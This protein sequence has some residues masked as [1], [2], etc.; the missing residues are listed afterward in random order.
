MSQTLEQVEPSTSAAKIR[1]ASIEPGFDDFN[2]KPIPPLAVVSL[3]LGICGLSGL[4]SPLGLLFAAF[5]LALGWVAVRQI[6][7]ADGGFSGGWMARSGVAVSAVLLFGGIGLHIYW[8]QT[9]LP[10]GCQRLSFSADISKKGFVIENNQPRFHPDVENLDGKQVF[11]KGYMYPEQKTDGLS[12]FILCRDN[13]QCCFGGQPKLTDMI[14]VRMSKGQTARY[15]DGMVSVSGTFRL[16]DLRRAGN[17]E[18]AF[19]LDATHFG[20]AKTWY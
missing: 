4:L 2:Y 19:E 3:L 7:R 10:E 11:L 16:R 12:T 8:Y 5:G 20:P 6:Q 13:G 17:L 15:G 9:E 18:P 1:P 14:K